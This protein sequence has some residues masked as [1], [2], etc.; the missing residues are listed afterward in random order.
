[1]YISFMDLQ[2]AITYK[3]TQLAEAWTTD[4]AK[5]GRVEA[6]LGSLLVGQF[7][8]PTG[9]LVSVNVQL[10]AWDTVRAVVVAT[11]TGFGCA[12]PQCAIKGSRSATPPNLT[13][14]IQD[15]VQEA[16][17]W[18]QAHAETCRALPTGQDQ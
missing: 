6:E 8:T 13:D 7:S 15:S 2:N 17:E 11:C 9:A 10:T 12:D 3:A 18:A 1:M 16:R 4:H 5:W 14:V